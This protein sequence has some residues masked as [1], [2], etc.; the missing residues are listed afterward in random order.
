VGLT[1]HMIFNF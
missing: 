1:D